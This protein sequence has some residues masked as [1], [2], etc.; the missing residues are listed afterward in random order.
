MAIV[1]VVAKL[2]LVSSDTVT[3]VSA[4]LTGVVMTEAAVYIIIT[5]GLKVVQISI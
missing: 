5:L 1:L 4:T 3:V 2:V